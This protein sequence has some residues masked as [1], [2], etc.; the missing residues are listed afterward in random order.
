MVSKKV[1]SIIINCVLVVLLIASSG[2]AH[3]QFTREGVYIV[4]PSMEPTLHNND[5]GRMKVGE[6]AKSKVMH[7]RFK[8]VV[9]LANESPNADNII[10][11]VIGLE[12][13]KIHID[14]KTGD[15]FINDKYIEQNFI[16]DQTRAK[17]CS[18]S[19]GLACDKDYIVPEGTIYVLGDNRGNSSDSE[20]KYGPIKRK[21]IVG[22]LEYISKKECQRNE[23]GT[24]DKGTCKA[25]SKR[26]Y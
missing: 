23:D 20:R 1:I 5:Y 3:F 14:S 9:F 21:Q 18:Y 13:E 26:W 6:N 22:V 15:L 12:G 4:G 10:K 24:F 19:I 2:L 25:T 16:D 7:Q 11:R 17:T 8:I